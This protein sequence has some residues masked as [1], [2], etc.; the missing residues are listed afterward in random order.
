[1]E[2]A[3]NQRLGPVFHF[4]PDAKPGYGAWVVDP[5]RPYLQCRKGDIASLHVP[6]I[7]YDIQAE[8]LVGAPDGPKARYRPS[9]W[10][11]ID[12][13]EG[14]P[15]IEVQPAYE[16]PAPPGAQLPVWGTLIPNED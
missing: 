3:R 12:C 6:L 13:Q 10:G 9:Q 7:D 8:F 5:K 11:F 15:A 2:L 1:L 16:G 4:D 14:K